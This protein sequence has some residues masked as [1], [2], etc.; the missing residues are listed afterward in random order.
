MFKNMNA[1]TGRQNKGF[2][3]IEL[4]IVVMIIGIIS[5]IGVPAFLNALYGARD[6][7]TIAD[8]RNVVIGLGMYRVDY[9]FV[10]QVTNYADLVPILRDTVGRNTTI[11]SYDGWGRSFL[12]ASPNLLD[13]TLKSLGKDGIL[14]IPAE[15]DSFRPDADTIV[16]N[17]VFVA[18]H[19]G[20]F[21]IMQ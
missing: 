20:K 10:P 7:R 18:S 12:Y 2:T 19:E 13:Y 16:I 14:G 17:G 9:E 21:S 5:G 8:M 4:L 6:R 15:I 3:L 1:L 11:P